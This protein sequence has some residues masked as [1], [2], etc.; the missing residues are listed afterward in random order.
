[1]NEPIALAAQSQIYRDAAHRFKFMTDDER[2]PFEADFQRELSEREVLGPVR[3]RPRENMPII[4]YTAPLGMVSPS[5]PV[6]A[7]QVKSRLVEKGMPAFD[8]KSVDD[9]LTVTK[10]QAA[11]FASCSHSPGAK[12]R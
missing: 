2:A 4:P 8:E 11:T 12:H 1:M 7:S 5:A 9:A 3:N 10:L 6:V